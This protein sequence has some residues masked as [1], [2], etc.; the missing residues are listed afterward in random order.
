V[1][2]GGTVDGRLAVF[3]WKS[4]KCAVK[5]LLNVEK[6]SRYGWELVG[7]SLFFSSRLAVCSVMVVG[8][9]GYVA[10]STATKVFIFNVRHFGESLFSRV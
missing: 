4:T 10:A 9:V 8:F 6:F 1:L 2:Y 5:M 3:E 7:S